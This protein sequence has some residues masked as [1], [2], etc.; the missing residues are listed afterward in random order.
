MTTTKTTVSHREE[1]LNR[2]NRTNGHKTRIDARQAVG[3][4]V[5]S[6][7]INNFDEM[8][9]GLAD[10]MTDVLSAQVEQKI[11]K[12]F[13]DGTFQQ[14]LETRLLQRFTGFNAQLD[15]ELM[16]L[17]AGIEA[18]ENPLYLPYAVVAEEVADLN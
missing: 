2:T 10:K 16:A 1:L 15:S 13:V 6:K 5:A 14:K 11:S 8:T 4:D 7:T 17:E 3:Q 18:L 9:D 12:Q